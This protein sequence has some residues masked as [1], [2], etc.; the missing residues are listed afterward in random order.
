MINMKN[1]KLKQ[2]K[3][4][5]LRVLEED[6]EV[7]EKI[8]SHLTET[9]GVKHSIPDAIHSLLTGDNSNMSVIHKIDMETEIYAKNILGLLQIHKFDPHNIDVIHQIITCFSGLLKLNMS[10]MVKD[11]QVI[12]DLIIGLGQ[13]AIKITEEK[14]KNAINDVDR[15]T[16]GKIIKN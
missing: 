6:K 12:Y 9:R 8:C 7:I 11:P 14:T 16:S 15:L 13:K 10:G 2:K 5:L 3:T 1:V 4:V